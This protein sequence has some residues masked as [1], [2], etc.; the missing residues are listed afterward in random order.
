M[1]RAILAAVASVVVGAGTLLGAPIPAGA[2]NPGPV[3]GDFLSDVSCPATS[4]C[5]AV[6]YQA[7]TSGAP[8]PLAEQWNGTA[9]TVVP[10]PVPPDTSANQFT[11][12]SCPTTSWCVAIGTDRNPSNW[13]SNFAEIYSGGAWSVSIPWDAYGSSLNSVSCLSSSDCVAVGQFDS[14]AQVLAEIWNGTTWGPISAPNPT[15]AI[16]AGF[17]A[18]TCWAKASVCFATGSADYLAFTNFTDTVIESWNGV[19]WTMAQSPN[20]A[21]AE[22]SALDGAVS[23]FDTCL[24]TGHSTT[25]G[26]NSPLAESYLPSTGLWSLDPPPPSPTTPNGITFNG[27]S[28][29][30]YSVCNT[31]GFYNNGYR[32]VT[33]QTTWTGSAWVSRSTAPPSFFS[34]FGGISCAGPFTCMAV[35]STSTPT[36]P[37]Q[38]L[39]ERWN[40]AG[41]TVVPSPSP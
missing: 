37:Q 2:A 21:G 1:R 15:G 25:G 28:C 5:M 4:W 18:V 35:G 20:V 38:T 7:P 36:T 33:L 8:S 39:A 19:S 27:V 16:H 10:T 31:A 29:T 23:C 6:G 9:W 26:V 40:G 11:H 22:V 3:I 34:L 30:M 17:D 32:Y 12:L 14:P 13:P 41:W 24:A